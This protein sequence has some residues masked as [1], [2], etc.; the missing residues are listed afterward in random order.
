MGKETDN[1]ERNA[2]TD[3]DTSLDCQIHEH[4]NILVVDDCI[5]ALHT[6]VRLLKKCG[7]RHIFTATSA[8]EGLHKLSSG[9]VDFDIVLLD[10][11]MPGGMDGLELLRTI[12][13]RWP[14]LPVVMASSVNNKEQVLLALQTGASDFL[15]KP[16]NKEMIRAKI[17][18]VFSS[19]ESVWRRS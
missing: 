18:G 9:E 14:Q 11:L 4:V 6:V 5:A 10:W 3:K 12:K 15:I 1:I 17:E 13:T 7:Y 8:K 19:A 2:Q 16:F